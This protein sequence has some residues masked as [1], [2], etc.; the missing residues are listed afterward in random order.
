LTGIASGTY[1][2]IVRRSG[3]SDTRL[4]VTLADTTTEYSLHREIVLAPLADLRLTY[5]PATAHDRTPWTLQLER[6]LEPSRNRVI[7]TKEPIPV[8]GYWSKTALQT[9]KYWASLLDAQGS[10]RA[11]KQFVVDAQGASEHLEVT[12][13]SVKGAVS[14]GGKPSVADVLFTWTDGAT[15]RIPTDDHGQYEG[16]LSHE[17]EW[18]VALRQRDSGV[19]LRQPNV[20]VHRKNESPVTLDFSL[21]PGELHG[22][23]TDESGNP[24]TASVIG[25]R[26][27]EPVQLSVMSGSD[28]RFDVFGIE[29][30]EIH[31]DASNEDGD[32]GDVVAMVSDSTEAVSLVLRHKVTLSVRVISPGGAPVAGALI[33]YSSPGWF[34]RTEETTTGPDG[35]ASLTMPA[36]TAAV[37]AV[38]LASG[39]PIRFASLSRA[40]SA[41]TVDVPLPASGGAL[42]YVHGRSYAW[43]VVRRAGGG[44]LGLRFLLTP[45]IGDLYPNVMPTGG[46]SF[47]VEPG[48]YFVCADLAMSER[49]GAAEVRAGDRAV[50]DADRIHQ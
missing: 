14:R 13:V 6:V 29:E 4:E 41:D 32:S 2:L 50:I 16:D 26:T 25:S 17:G 15:V 42:E 20:S 43:P 21:P 49:C 40:G 39:F 3:Y 31:L 22:I 28:G 9:G 12:Y 33:R 37:D 45:P 11:R 44:P 30:G 36:N 27:H 34:G 1:T 23:V 5:S 46:F 47:N 8:T 18:R 19:V 7:V 35:T 38:V 48:S 24:A 10:V